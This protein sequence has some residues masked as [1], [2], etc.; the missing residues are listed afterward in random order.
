[1]LKFEGLAPSGGAAKSAIEQGL[2]KVNGEVETRKRKK[3]ISGD[4]IHFD[5]E[6]LIIV[7]E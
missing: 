6:D 1:M 4:I 3:I 2:V 7:C 5:S